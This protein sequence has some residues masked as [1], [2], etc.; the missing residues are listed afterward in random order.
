MTEQELH[1]QKKQEV[2]QGAEPTKPARQFVPAVDIF[3]TESAVTVVAEMP[4]V[5]KAGV[6]INLED[7]TL[8]IKGLRVAEQ[9]AGE[10]MLLHEYETGHYI[11]RF[12]ISEAIDRA[13]IEAKMADGILTLTLPKVEQAKPRRIEV[14][15]S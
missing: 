3:E 8:T 1:V 15:G 2:K 4:G 12:T 11:R 9:G 13:R 5:D 7:D 6:D 10:T 14:Q